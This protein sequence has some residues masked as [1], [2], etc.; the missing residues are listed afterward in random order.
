MQSP[1]RSQNWQALVIHRL[2]PPSPS[3]FV[4]FGRHP[5]KPLSL[6][7]EPINHL[8]KT[9]S[10]IRNFSHAPLSPDRI[11]IAS[12]LVNRLGSNLWLTHLLI[13]W[14]PSQSVRYIS[15]KKKAIIILS[16]S[17]ESKT[18][19]FG[20]ELAEAEPEASVTSHLHGPPNSS[21][22]PW[23]TFPLVELKY[24]KERKNQQ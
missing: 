19:W 1:V 9:L 10:F 4:H 22:L 18:G 16:Q 21:N 17:A 24:Q 20:E 3:L 23:K 2:I 5:A 11:F 15:S 8:T 12:V 13:E 7:N 6:A 14:D